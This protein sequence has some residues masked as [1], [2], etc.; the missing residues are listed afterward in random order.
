MEMKEM[1]AAPKTSQYANA[2]IYSFPPPVLARTLATVDSTNRIL[3][4]IFKAHN[5]IL[6]LCFAASACAEKG[7]P[8]P[9]PPPKVTVARPVRKAVT[10][11]LEYTGNTQAINTVQ[12]VARVP[13]YLDQVL[14]HDGQFVERDQLLFLIQQNTY[15]ETL[16]EAE[17][18]IVQQKAQLDYADI[19]LKRY[20]DLVQKS[21][22][23]RSDVD[24]WQNQ[25][26][27][28]AANLN[29]A[30]AQ[31]NLASLNLGYTEIRAP[32]DGRMD[33]RLVD[34][35]NLV[36]SGANTILAQISQIDPIYVYFNISDSDLARLTGQTRWSPGRAN[37]M[38]W[39]VFM[40]VLEDKGYPNQGRLDFAATNLNAST[41]TLLLRGVFP[42]KSGS[43]LPGLYARVRV[44]MVQRTA[45]LVPDA[46]V[47]SD[48]Q[49]SY[50]LIVDDKNIIRRRNVR[51]GSIH[52]D[53]CVIE[54]GV[55][56]GE[57]VVVNGLLRSIPGSPVAPEREQGAPSRQ[58]RRP[59][60]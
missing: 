50:V 43:I 47:S 6:C 12:L 26:N 30:E 16:R 51:T 4:R 60:P 2:K 49:G 41:G 54:E 29:S 55:K 39:P 24:N 8:A 1:N 52:N 22:V 9:L 28:A 56:G 31:R 46:A 17:A 19:Q 18:S 58:K 44:P 5:L 38:R 36:G 37:S 40:G 23:A 21:A 7:A 15:Q 32:F 33:R 42:N 20:A 27:V 3:D 59:E 13:G 53:L 10:D 25:K 34:P 14:F 48:Q 35:G 57:W 45:L 11:Y